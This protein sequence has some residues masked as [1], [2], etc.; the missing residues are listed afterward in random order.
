MGNFQLSADVAELIYYRSEAVKFT[1]TFL[2]VQRNLNAYMFR[3]K[4]VCSAYTC[5]AW[6]VTHERKFY[7][8]SRNL[9]VIVA[10][11]ME[12]LAYNRRRVMCIRI[13]PL[14][15]IFPALF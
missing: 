15:V 6:N 12:N 2:C 9:T 11:Y 14:E 10:A 1:T 3:I 7:S 4:G 5:I 13:F 8:N